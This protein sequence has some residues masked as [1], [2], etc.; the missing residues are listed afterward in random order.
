MIRTTLSDTAT[1]TTPLTGSLGE[2][3]DRPD[4]VPKVTG[5]FAFSSDL[6]AEGMLW[7]RTL[8]SPHAAARIRSIDTSRATAMDG[9]HAVLLAEDVP[10]SPTYGMEHRDQPVFASDVVRYHGEP[11][12]AVAADHPELALRALAAIEVDYDPLEPLADPDAAIT[13]PP[14]HPDGNVFRHIPLRHGNPD[15][16]DT[17]GLVTVEGTYEV[18]MQDQAFLGPESGLAVPDGDGGVD[19]WISTQ[20]LHVDRDQVAACLDLPHDKVRLSLA[21]VGGAFGGREDVSLQIHACLLALVTGRPVKMLYSR[22]ESFY[23]HVHRHPA[24]LWYRH[25]ATPDGDLVKVEARVVLDGGAYA[26]SSTAVIANATCFAAGPYRI[27]HAAID[28]WAVRTN[29]PPCGA[30]RGFGAVQTCI[31]HEAQMDRLADA[32]GMDPV[33]LRLRN[34]LA[35]GDTLLTGQVITGT[36]PV[37]EVIEAAMAHPLPRPHTLDDPPQMLPGGTGMTSTADRIRRG[38]GM[39]VGFKNLMFSEG[40]DDHSTAAVTLELDAHGRPTATAQCAAAE[41]GQGFTTLALQI[42]RSELGVERVMLGPTDTSIGSAGSTS[43][44]RQTWMSGGAVQLACHA[45]RDE[46]LVRASARLGIP[47]EGARRQ[48]LTLRDGHVVEV[49]GDRRVPITDLLA[50]SP[51][52]RVREHHHPPTEPL[53]ANGQGNAHVS[54]AFAAHRAVVDVDPDLGLLRVVQ[55]ATGQ[56]VGRVLNPRA[57]VGQIEGGIAQGVGLAIMEEVLVHD[58]LVRNPSFTDYLIPTMLDM[59]EVLATVIE[60]PEPGAPF[61]AKG[62]GEPP[63]IS[64]TPAVVAAIRDAT[65]AALTRVPVRPQDIALQAGAGVR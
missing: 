55:V 58:G 57:V 14:I 21:G 20:W 36:A 28:G 40:F 43:A 48:L 33:A 32:L 60:Q 49:D 46:L 15:E 27:P 29:N 44:S 10:G 47:A 8:R 52:R 11:V 59:P 38:V 45:V 9:V 6:H 17:S 35:T 50:D 3:A 39:A 42:L 65:G 4:G 62:V 2:N 61:G 1:P 37:R 23:G 7:G 51:I 30:M 18:G 54:F 56:D 5:D 26:S 22:E 31:A 12:A 64:S 41:V 19:L 16:V 13:A 34:A 25:H 53:D 63:T 24:R